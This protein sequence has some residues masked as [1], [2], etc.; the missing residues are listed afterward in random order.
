MSPLKKKWLNKFSDKPA[1][2]LKRHHTK[3]KGMGRDDGE[4][5]QAIVT[6]FLYEPVEMER[7]FQEKRRQK[8]LV[9]QQGL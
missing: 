9:F 4:N 5:D 8:L 7:P 1:F 6:K 3:G 2:R